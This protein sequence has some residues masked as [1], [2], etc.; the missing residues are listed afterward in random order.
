[1]NESNRGG[2][3]LRKLYRTLYRQLFY[4]PFYSSLAPRN[5]SSLRFD[6]EITR[7]RREYQELITQFGT[8]LPDIDRRYCHPVWQSLKTEIRNYLLTNAAYGFLNYEKVTSTMVRRGWGTPQAIEE[9]YISRT[10]SR[11]PLLREL[12]GSFVESRVG[13]PWLESRRFRCS[14]NTIGL[15][16]TFARLLDHYDGGFPNPLMVIEFGGGYGNLARIFKLARP[17]ATYT[18]IDF[19]ELLLLQ[20]VFL[21]LNF[22]ESGVVLH[23]SAPIASKPG[24]FNLVPVY[25]VAD[26]AL[27]GDIFISTFA[28]SE[29]PAY[30]QNLVI[31]QRFF[32]C[33]GIYVTG[34][35]DG[36]NPEKDKF[37]HHPLIHDGAKACFPRVVSRK[38]HAIDKSYELIG[39]LKCG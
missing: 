24:L 17:C 20:A 36:S 7:A 23:G 11:Q 3:L 29:A 2:R 15:L 21:R 8:E 35:E 14:S 18:I 5:Y 22:G 4:R 30:V 16:Y 32:G 27:L 37:A 26:S 33:S 12:L 31:G 9:E 38:F 19:P 28:L 13:E 25:S 39:S 10:A 6:V 34:L 1:M